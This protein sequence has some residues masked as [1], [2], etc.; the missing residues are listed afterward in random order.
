MNI[1]D[2]ITTG[3]QVAALPVGSVLYSGVTP[4]Q[5]TCDVYVRWPHGWCTDGIDGFRTWL[6]EVEVLDPP[7]TIL[8][9][10]DEAPRPER[11]VKAEALREYATAME[12]GCRAGRVPPD[13]VR[14]SSSVGEVIASLRGRADRIEAGDL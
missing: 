3:A 12:D 2:V 13:S 14:I 9:L 10:P 7:L 11:V 4:S 1:G 5:S 6:T 8:A